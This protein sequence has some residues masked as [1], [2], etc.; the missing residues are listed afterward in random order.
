MKRGL[1]FCLL[2]N[3]VLLLVAQSNAF[4]ELAKS[5]E[6]SGNYY[7][8][9]RLMKIVAESEKDT[10]FYINDI[11]NIATYYSNLNEPDSLIRYNKELIL[12]ADKMG[13]TSDSIS[14]IYVCNAALN[15]YRGKIYPDAVELAKRALAIRD[16][17]YGKTSKESIDLIGCL[18][19]NALAFEDL[20]GL[21]EFYK[22]EI[23]RSVLDGAKS[24]AYEDAIK[25]IRGAA[26]QLDSS[27]PNFVVSWIEPYYIELSDRSI[28]PQM[29]Y[30]YE[31]ILLASNLAIGNLQGADKYAHI[32]EERVYSA[33]KDNIPV[34]DLARICMKVANY[35]VQCGNDITARI[36]INKGWELLENNGV[37]PSIT[38]LIDRHIA[39][40]NIKVGPKGESGMMAQWIIDSST[41]IIEAA[42]EDESTL[43]FFYESRAWAYENLKKFNEA[44]EDIQTAINLN[45]LSSRKKKLAQLFMHKGEF[46]KAESILLELLVEDEQFSSLSN[47][48]F[49]DL[50][51][52]YWM[53]GNKEALSKII[54]IDFQILKNEVK[55]AFAY[56]N[57]DER[58]K[59]I[60]KS[61][62]GSTI[63]FDVY[64]YFS[65]DGSQWAFGNEM[66]YN[67]ALAQKSLLLNTSTEIKRILEVAPDTLQSKV[68]EYY[69]LDSIANS[70]GFWYEDSYI[71]NL[72]MELMPFVANNHDFLRQLEITFKDIQEHLKE[73]EATI[74]FVNLWG[75]RPEMFI[76]GMEDKFNPKI[77]VGALILRKN[78]GPYFVSISDTEYL[79]RTIGKDDYDEMLMLDMVYSDSINE[80]ISKMVWN[81]LEKYLTDIKTIY[82]SPA[83]I[84][85]S[86][87]LDFLLS[88]N[89]EYLSEDYKLYRV[90]STREILNKKKFNDV[91]EG[92]LYGDI[93]YSVNGKVLSD[94]QTAKYRS[95]TRSGFGSL[96][97][98]AEEVETISQL[99]K[100]K[101]VNYI[102][103]RRYDASE[104]SFRKLQS[105]SPRILHIAT[106]G[107]SYSYERVHQLID[108]AREQTEIKGEP[109]GWNFITFQGGKSDLHFSGLAFAGAQDTWRVNDFNT[110][111]N[112]DSKNDGILL[113]SEIAKL[114]LSNTD[115]V[116]LS[117]CETALGE[118]KND[119]VY[120]LQRAFKLAGVNSIIM[121]LWKVD[122]DATQ[123]LVSAFYHN[124]LHGKTKRESLLEAQKMVRETEGY[125]DPSLWAGWILLDALD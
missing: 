98:T 19:Y 45:P 5:Y 62:L 112:I 51:Y 79:E 114:D 100:S 58:E 89:R 26:N 21:Q 105:S 82:Y 36:R 15:Y 94:Y 22:I 123:K 75:I 10:E 61:L 116:F 125:S 97:H 41:P 8:A 3:V 73:D 109:I 2:I 53:S 85:N 118:I 23:E 11:A 80:K 16:N 13:E 54:P 122:D 50:T 67:L 40:R 14:E 7:E 81:P 46:E 25:G 44:I 28:L 57:E 60:T 102:I 47:S 99:L 72:R 96:F 33:N 56:M 78:S 35:Y 34:E 37:M 18:K 39:E 55:N 106:H 59:Y 20:T 66:A 9:A 77:G 103:C 4:Y 124:Y 119:G 64:T 92:V 1:S 43:A 115:L 12:L 29:Q 42:T 90:S 17:I 95:I 70:D 88:S 83:G 91:E 27:H 84:I 87:N 48:V 117:A 101:D 121:S 63:N 69:K 31:I 6:E 74:E 120:G 65:K 111:Q 108:F 76:N 110:L 30:E 86:I 68:Q 113:S 71:R 52:L 107:F 93:S 24:N 104:T 38:V 32:L 49:S